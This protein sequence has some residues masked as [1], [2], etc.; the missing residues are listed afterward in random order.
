MIS[1]R[2]S[3][4]VIKPCKKYQSRV[5]WRLELEIRI[6]IYPVEELNIIFTFLPASSV[7]LIHAEVLRTPARCFLILPT[8]LWSWQAEVGAVTIEWEA[9]VGVVGLA[10]GMVHLHHHRQL[11]HG[12]TMVWC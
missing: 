10:V 6:F 5:L 8:M 9:V 1:Y 3:F 12:S 7:I 2:F 11:G 4:G